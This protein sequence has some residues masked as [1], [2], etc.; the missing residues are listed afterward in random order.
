M[1]TMATFIGRKQ[2]LEDLNRF[3]HKQTASL[4]VIKGRRRIGKSRL[5][6]EFG[7]NLKMYSLIGLPPSPELT[8][9]SQRDDF[10]RQLSRLFNIP[11][12]KGDDWSDL[13]YFLAMQTQNEKTII[14]LDEISWMGS[15]DPNFLG[16]LKSAWDLYFKKNDQL[17]LILCGSVSSWIDKNILSSTAFLGR[18]SFTLN[19]TELK[20]NDCSKFWNKNGAMISYYEKFKIIAVTG[21]IPRYLE[22]ID[23]NQ[24][25]EHNIKQLCFKKGGFLTS[26]FEKIFSD[27]F[28]RRSKI[29]KDLIIC[30]IDGP[31]SIKEICARLGVNRTGLIS[32]YLEDLV[33][34]NFLA[35]DYT[36]LLKSGKYSLLSRFRI[37]DNYLRFYLKYIQAYM[38]LIEHDGFKDKSLNSLPGWSSI[39]GLQFQNL[40]LHNRHYIRNSLH[41]LPE[42]VV[43]D[44]P[45]FQK[46]TTGHKGCQID[47][48]IQTKFNNLFAC[49]IKFSKN[50]IST[51]IIQEMQDKLAR[52][53]LPRGFS[54][55]PVLIH[56]NGVNE[57]VE[58]SGYFTKIIDFSQFL[59]PDF[60]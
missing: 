41:I 17:I 20:L 42:D 54:C 47:Y 56:V 36:W 39:M 52:L 32:S 48:M 34:A 51:N 31:A 18:I 28:S 33:K 46:S 30:C 11:L 58:D 14:S 6:E 21:G 45:Y 5:I 4:I 1:V 50:E 16:K 13:F 55:W 49:E 26:E 40:V 3:L 23:P 8:A 60:S 15:K 53:I 12:L 25:A 37:S 27:L 59:N 43:I 24:S 57:K 44:N 35:R 38:Q 22:E 9:Q 2:E 10:C 19:L 29:Y 7:K